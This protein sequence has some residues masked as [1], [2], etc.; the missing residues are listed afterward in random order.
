MSSFWVTICAEVWVIPLK[1]ICVCDGVDLCPH[2]TLSIA[3]PFQEGTGAIS[4]SSKLQ[5][6][7]AKSTTEAEYH[8]AC[9]AGSELMFLRNLFTEFGY[10]FTSPSTLFIDNMSA[11]NV[12]KD[13][14]HHGRMKHL[15]LSYYWLRDEVN[16]GIIRPVHCPTQEMPADIL[17]KPLPREK[18]VSCCKMLGLQPSGGSVDVMTAVRSD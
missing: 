17:T 3:S 13:P 15:P 7:V 9:A 4:W 16:K 8:A 11:I 1:F 5:T 14:E 6:V 12:A 18:V 2:N 10:S